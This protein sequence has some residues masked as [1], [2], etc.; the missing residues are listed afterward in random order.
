MLVKHQINPNLNWVETRTL[1]SREQ[2]T[3]L[4]EY[5]I[6]EEILE[7]VM[8][9]YEQSNYIHEPTGE[10]ELVSLHIPNTSAEDN[11]YTTTPISFLINQHTLFTFNE[12]D[13]ILMNLDMK[14]DTGY[15]F[16]DTSI[17]FMLE[18]IYFLMSSYFPVLR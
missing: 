4:D 12:S 15:E 8:D 11:R 17:S 7:Y 13:S 2:N 1:N 18:K 5:Q 9:S 14:K 16:E 10:Q 6:S 3:L